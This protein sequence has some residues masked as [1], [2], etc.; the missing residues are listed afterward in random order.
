MTAAEVRGTAL[1]YHS[2]QEVLNQPLT[3]DAKTQCHGFLH[4]A[5]Q[6]CQVVT[7]TSAP[8]RW[9]R[10]MVGPVLAAAVGAAAWM[11][12]QVP[13]A[14]IALRIFG[15]T[16]DRPLSSQAAWNLIQ[17]CLGEPAL[18]EQAL[19][20]IRRQTGLLLKLP[21]EPNAVDVLEELTRPRSGVFPVQVSRWLADYFREHNGDDTCYAAHYRNALADLK[22]LNDRGDLVQMTGSHGVSGRLSKQDWEALIHRRLPLSRLETRAGYTVARQFVVEYWEKWN[23]P[24]VCRE[25]PVPVN[26]PGA[27]PGG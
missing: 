18:N 13:S 23:P 21:A 11:R 5:E 20:K 8:A 14:N 16:G 26:R 10:S 6:E 17:P 3:E 9:A 2:I 25:C 24:R 7:E 15:L 12:D 19:F 27:Q 4:W 1:V 22:T